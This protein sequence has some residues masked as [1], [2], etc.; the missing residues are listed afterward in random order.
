VKSSHA[1]LLKIC[2]LSQFVIS[3]SFVI[4]NQVVHTTGHLME[5]FGSSPL[6]PLA[7]SVG[8]IG[9]IQIN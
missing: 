5:F 4:I 7:C 8:D 3:Q 2:R 1:I 6:L 9:G